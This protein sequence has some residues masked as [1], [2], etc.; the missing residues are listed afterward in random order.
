MFARLAL[1][2]L[3]CA[4]V[5]MAGHKTWE[6][7]LSAS[8]R[9]RVCKGDAGQGSWVD[10]TAAER[11]STCHSRCYVS[12]FDAEAQT[13]GGPALLCDN[14][15]EVCSIEVYLVTA[16]CCRC[17]TH[18]E[19]DS[20]QQGLNSEF[21]QHETVSQCEVPFMGV[22]VNGY[23]MLPLESQ[24]NL[25]EHALFA[26]TWVED[27][28]TTNSVRDCPAQSSAGAMLVQTYNKEYRNGRYPDPCFADSHWRGS[29]LSDSD[30]LQ[31]SQ[32][33]MWR[34]GCNDVWF[35]RQLTTAEAPREISCKK[36]PNMAELLVYSPPVY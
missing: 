16:P 31:Q 33:V 12:R 5:A 13:N 14:S 34:P 19:T 25:T 7:R 11:C 30:G 10:R 1:V 18:N 23:W 20:L 29:H 24:C 2:L 8:L 35:S 27:D 3:L 22:L 15:G 4:G 36:V 32:F 6:N 9:N 21:Q 26:Q 28:Y 17:N